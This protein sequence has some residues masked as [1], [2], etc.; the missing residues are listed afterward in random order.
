MTLALI[1]LVDGNTVDDKLLSPY[2]SWLTSS[3]MKRYQRF[4]RPMRQRQFLI[5][6]ILLRFALSK[7]LTI[8]VNAIS[9]TER[10]N[11][12]PLL[13]IA[14]QTVVPGFSLSHTGNWV[15][16]AVSATSK[17]GLD[18]ELLD[19]SRDLNALSLKSFSSEE[20]AWFVSLPNKA[21]VTAFYQL[22]SLKEA[23]YKLNQTKLTLHT[24]SHQK[25]Y[26][27]TLPHSD[28]SIVLCCEQEL[29]ELPKV[30]MINWEMWQASFLSEQK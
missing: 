7:T 21:K 18:I 8:P 28:I 5:G 9:L 10:P 29:T 14:K 24:D 15:A 13:H 23:R 30:E 4:S 3:E 6:H 12:A 26:T 11:Q 22:W 17:L 25:E 16:C 27:Y 2:I 20:N 19:A 1:W